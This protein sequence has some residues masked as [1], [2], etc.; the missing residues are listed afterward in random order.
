MVR[1]GRRRRAARIAELEAFW[2]ARRAAGEDVTTF[3]EELAQLHLDTFLTPLDDTM[4]S[5][6]EQALDAYERAKAR[7]AESAAAS[8]VTDVT[9]TLADGRFAH[10]C[11]LAGRDG[12][13]RPT[14]REPCFFNP[15]HGP[16]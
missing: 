11:V 10:A 7:L 16:G 4:R 9:R 15:D 14:R 1:I 6:Y 5:D 3:G 13:P 12:T 8:D 2:L